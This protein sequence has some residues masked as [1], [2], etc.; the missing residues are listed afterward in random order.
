M[1]DNKT[2]NVNDSAYF[3][4]ELYIQAHVLSI[5]FLKYYRVGLAQSVACPPLAR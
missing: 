4:A 5:S 1:G 3:S 2:F